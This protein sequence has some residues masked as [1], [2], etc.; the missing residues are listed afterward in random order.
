MDL[1]IAL[2]ATGV[3]RQDDA[4][5]RAGWHS[6]RKDEGGRHDRIGGSM[7]LCAAA[8]KTQ[9]EPGLE[10]AGLSILWIVLA[11]GLSVLGSALANQSAAPPEAIDLGAYSPEAR[12]AARERLKTTQVA[13]FAGGRHGFIRGE[14]V[15]LDPDDW[16]TEAIMFKRKVL[17][18]ERFALSAF[19][20]KRLP[21]F[22]LGV[23]EKKGLI[24]V[25][26]LAARE[27]KE[28]F[29]DERGL[30]IVTDEPLTLSDSQLI[31]SI[32]TLFD[33]PEKFA[34]PQ[35][36][37]RN[38]PSL[39][40]WGKFVNQIKVTDEQFA[41]FEGPET[42]WRWMPQKA[43]DYTGLR[44]QELNSPVPEAGVHPRVLFSPEDVPIISSRIRSS[45][46][47]AKSLLDMQ[48]LLGQSFLDPNTSDGEI[49]RRLAAGNVKDLVLNGDTFERQEPGIFHSDV[50]YLP[51]CL[52]SMALYCLLL[53]DDDLGR[54]T[55]S[56]ISHYYALVEPEIDGINDKPEV[57][58]HHWRDVRAAVG[59][60]DLGMAYDFSAKWMTEEQKV[61]MRRVIAK[62]VAGRRGYGQN[63]VARMRD[64]SWVTKE[65][66]IFL[67]NLAL[68]GEEGFDPE[69]HDAGVETVR[70]F[71]Q[72]GI[73]RHGLPHEC[74][75]TS[76]AGLEFQLLSMVALARRSDNMLG[77]P[78]WRRMMEAQ[79]QCTSPD[80]T[81]VASRGTGEG[82]PLSRQIVS[83]FKVFYP[84]DKH[85]D[86][87]LGRSVP[88]RD[89]DAETYRRRLP[90]N[91]GRMRLP[92]PTVPGLTNNLLYDADGHGATRAALELPLD[93]SDPIQ[94]MFSS[95]SDDGPEALW[96]NMQARPDLYLGGG[97]LHH[98]AGSFYLQA[99]GVTWGRDGLS[100]SDGAS[101]NHSVI[102]ID[103]KGQDG[104]L[105]EMPVKVQ[106]LGAALSDD[107]AVATADLKYAYDYVWTTR[108]ESWD[109]PHAKAY[110]WE[111]ETDPDV[112]KIFK[113][114]QNYRINFYR[115]PLSNPWFPTLR[116]PFNPVR[117]AFRSA[118]LVRGAHPY[119]V[120]VDDIRK[121]DESH[122]YEWQMI[123]GFQ[124]VA[125]PGLGAED[126]VLSTRPGAGAAAGNPMLLIREVGPS[127]CK[128]QSSLEGQRTVISTEAVD[129]RFRI[130]MIPFRWGQALPQTVVD[131][132]SGAAELRWSDQADQ[133]LFEIG[134]DERTRLRVL[135][136]EEEILRSK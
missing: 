86:F 6:E 124:A 58:R 55:A 14:R 122:L 16:R 15:S 63:G 80:G 66:T 19:G 90:A 26:D 8:S 53:N 70:A 45:V 59:Y 2:N 104:D 88:L 67:A 43:Y 110:E 101:K 25:A 83:A 108:I 38:L 100:P 69:V 75:G 33:T 52:T 105:G 21:W 130:V 3:V 30:V 81:I 57:Y 39:K 72:W 20:L 85:A 95:R 24:A 62:A 78:H 89:F 84:A 109:Q 102:L 116:A 13:V 76:G 7:S 42:R 114:T 27:K 9:C 51:N 56:A 107:G 60:M 99:H 125:L 127:V 47:G 91:P 134:S 32:I 129:P 128:L 44:A 106:Y 96:I 41:L 35:I 123:G 4:E 131:T 74:N 87:L 29:T 103:G 133:L 28:V 12:A 34:D 17:V 22:G 93:F 10:R 136:D 135:R 65:L 73:D 1:S 40:A 68:E 97:P 120:L 64:N 79:I 92:G 71:L 31:D 50:A 117:Y 18:P 111:I 112:V 61:L 126:L 48:F 49:F 98:D 115:P 11:I 82:G 23:T 94:G 119:V 118:A 36:A 37:Y 132:A 113:G 5:A 121:D 54:Q 77:H 46:T